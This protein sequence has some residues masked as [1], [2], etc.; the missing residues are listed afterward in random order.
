M[1]EWKELGIFILL[2]TLLAIGGTYLIYRGE[3]IV[4]NIIPLEGE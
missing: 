4:P 1:R 2:V 3:E